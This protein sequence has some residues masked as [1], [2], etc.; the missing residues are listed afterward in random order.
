MGTLKDMTA[1]ILGRYSIPAKVEVERWEAFEGVD[2]KDVKRLL[3]QN[4]PYYEIPPTIPRM[5]RNTMV[6]PPRQLL[7]CAGTI[8]VV[9]RNLLHQ[10]QSEIRKHL[11]TDALKILMVD[12]ASKRAIPKDVPKADEGF[13]WEFVSDLP[14]PARLMDYDIVLFTRTRFEQEI[15]DGADEKGRRPGFG[16]PRSCNCPYIGSSSIPDCTCKGQIYESP[17]MKVHWLRIIVDE[18]HNFSSSVSNA[19]LVSKRLQ[20][21]RR[22]I[23]SGTPAKDL[24]GVEVDHETLGTELHDAEISREQAVESRREFDLDNDSTKSVKALGTLASN[25]L[26]VRPWADP[27]SQD[28]LD[29]EDYIYR[30]E[31]VQRK[32][33][34]G[35]SACFRR[36]LEGLVVKTRPE[37]VEKDIKLPAKR[38][39]VVYLK[40]CWF[41]KMVS[42]YPLL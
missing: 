28:R 11:T 13:Q 17:L 1:S 2:L 8:V 33:Y 26:M 18:G 4:T 39:R 10:W 42:I 16:A 7:M 24:I 5:N 32:T 20:V 14:S 37:D 22:W 15:Q 9:P 3:K 21:E 25:F 30:H 34:S 19:V 12:T 31:H 27:T 41:D 36:T 35:F 29:W 40:P 6:P 38:H 23:V